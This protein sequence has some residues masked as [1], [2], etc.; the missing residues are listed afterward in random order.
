L[1]KVAFPQAK[2]SGRP[3][4]FEQRKLHKV[5]SSGNKKRQSQKQMINNKKTK[6]DNFRGWI[7]PSCMRI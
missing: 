3:T 5:V 2:G 7:A 1:N 4:F 6:E